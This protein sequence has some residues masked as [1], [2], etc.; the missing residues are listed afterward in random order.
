MKNK[1]KNSL[2]KLTAEY[3]RIGKR[4]KWIILAVLFIIFFLG[5]SVAWGYQKVLRPV[6]LPSINSQ[7]IPAVISTP[8]S[9]T[10]QSP[11]KEIPVNTTFPVTL[12]I[13]TKDQPIEA[14]NFSLQFDPD[15]LKVSDITQGDFF[16]LYPKIETIGAEINIYAAANL[17][18]NTFIAPRGK[19]SIAVISFEA[20]KAAE[21][22][23][24]SI[25]KDK[26]IV[27]SR[28]NNLTGETGD[29]EISIK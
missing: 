19:G 26:T 8:I 1:I 11:Q 29:L 3:Y 7:P 13:D 16:Q 10:L 18:N 23:R 15:Y 12:S 14:A 6:K 28:G 2:Q 17:V 9:L 21:S 24:I 27:A 25:V 4:E 22:T 20:I 5:F